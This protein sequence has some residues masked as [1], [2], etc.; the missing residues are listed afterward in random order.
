[1]LTK[2]ELTDLFDRIGT[3]QPGRTMIE[4]ARAC[5]PVRE[6]QSR[7]GN[8]ITLLASRK[9]GR[10]IRTESRHIEFAAAIN[11]EYDS[12]VLEYYAQ[13]C[14]LK[15]ELIDDVTGE[16][17]S[18]QHFPDFLVIRQDAI[19]LEEW[20]SQDKLERLAQRFP[21]RY[22]RGSDGLWHSPQIERQLAELGIRYR[23]YSDRAI[24]RKRVENLLHL[25]DYFHPATPPCPDATVD[26]LHAVLREHGAVYLSELL[27]QPLGFDADEL[28]KAVADRLVEADLDREAL[29]QPSRARLYRD[30]TL[31]EFLAA[32]I[33]AG[34][35]PG[36]QS[37][38]IDIA[39][40]AVF[41]FES[42]K[43]TISLVGEADFVC[44][45]D[46]GSTRTLSRDWLLEAVEKQHV[47]PIEG[48][49]PA[50]LNLSRYSES[51]LKIAATR[52]VMLQ[53]E[54]APVSDRTLR[55]WSARQHAAIANGGHEVLALVPRTSAKGNRTA[56]LSDDQEH[57]LTHIINTKWISHEAK[58]FKACYRELLVLFESKGIRAPSYP[59]VIERIKAVEDA[60]TLR[61]RH[62]KR[63][64]YQL[65]EFV[66]VLYLD[67]PAHGSRPFQYV[68]IDHTQL[69]IELVSGR[70]GK[71]IGRPWLSFAVDAYSRR[72]VALYLT[73][74]PPSYHSVMMTVRDMVQ[75]HS[76]LP[77]FF[78]VDNGRDFMSSA[79]ESFLEALGVHLRFRPAGQPR[80][81]AVLERVFGR[82]NTEYIHNLSGNTKA[83]KNVRMTTGKHLP[84]NFAEWTLE[85]MYYGI[86]YWATEFYE[87]QPHP[88]LDCSPR[89]A[90][91]RG[92]RHSGA[93]PQRRILFNEDFLIATCPPVD[94]A[95]VRQVH[96]QRGVKV[97]EMLYWHADFR[98]PR[99][100]GQKWAV[101]Y[102]PWDASS[103]Y[104]LLKDRWVRAQCR[105]LIGLG[106]LIELERRALTEEYTH[107]SGSLND[108]RAR[109]RLR[110]FMQVFTPEG[111]MVAALDRQQENKALYNTLQL[112]N[113]RPVQASPKTWLLE[114]TSSQLHDLAD[115]HDTDSTVSDHNPEIHQQEQMDDDLF[116]FETF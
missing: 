21:Y 1:M 76:R 28:N 62:G 8:V 20:K 32:D 40:G 31:R 96:N 91:Q 79:F 60:R 105:N 84:V 50:N 23:I 83:T 10:E 109:Q 58:N 42:Q 73:F 37:F 17:R 45:V 6:V 2:F 107:R 85:S 111:A 36:Q 35:I 14:E 59:T 102:D 41:S 71:P 72:I 9:M 51:D 66:D 16:I 43:F 95:G 70:T 18:I 115:E 94:R 48:I 44:T 100:A 67:T 113:I 86:S 116:D 74:D 68:H 26:R 5:A 52:S 98:D 19:T 108:D 82:A 15:L 22:Q 57:W 101:R 55:R 49:T 88:A 47:Q 61:T 106:Q 7:G 97:N 63:M 25:A 93:R 4:R 54:S 77:E 90:F 114:E 56:R 65:S 30:A 99:Y 33:K 69:D 92:M 87:Q 104:V 11:H 24:P 81:G 29:T 53:S 3:P 103:V 78:V 13:P 89:E 38:V 64:A 80:H 27:A 12:A 39:P 112:S 110:E 75:R 46:D 34:Q